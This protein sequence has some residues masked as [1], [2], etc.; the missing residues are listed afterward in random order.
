MYKFERLEVYQ[1]ALDY[2]DQIY[3]VVDKHQELLRKLEESG[4]VLAR[5]LQAMRR[6]LVK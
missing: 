3:G 2:I 6:S 5:K 4:R 1:L